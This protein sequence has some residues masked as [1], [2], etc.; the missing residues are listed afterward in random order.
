MP[1]SASACSVP[2][3]MESIPLC[4]GLAAENFS[5]PPTPPRGRRFRAK[6]NLSLR[7]RLDELAWA[8]SDGFTDAASF[9]LVF[10]FIERFKTLRAGDV[11]RRQWLQG[12]AF[13]SLLSGLEGAAYR[14]AQAVIEQLFSRVGLKSF[15][16]E[17]APAY[18]AF[19]GIETL[20]DTV[21]LW[22]AKISPVEFGTRLFK[23]LSKSLFGLGGAKL[24]AVCGLAFGPVGVTVFTVLGCVGGDAL[25]SAL[26]PFGE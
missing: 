11:C 19:L 25:I 16:D 4:L 14:S 20:K 21:E 22:R 6:S 3:S 17:W 7:P 26:W 13:V 5:A 12:L 10:S 24:G 2:L 15:A 1:L 23:N 9:E 18:V 8:L